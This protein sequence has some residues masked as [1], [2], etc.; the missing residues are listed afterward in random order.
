MALELNSIL[1]NRYQ[2][3]GLAAQGGMGSVYRAF[4]TNL[5]VP[6]A[7]KE[8]HFQTQEAR[9]QFQRE[10][11][12]LARLRHPG[13]PRVL[14]HFSH[15]DRQYLVMEF[16]EGPD[17]WE[18]VKQNGGPFP[19]RQ[20]LS[21][22]DQVCQAVSYLHSQV[23]P[24]IH[25]DIK[26]Q[27][28]KRMPND[29]VVLVDFGVAKEGETNV[30]TAAGAR[31]VTPGFSPPEQYSG[32]SGPA[33]DIYS[34]G[35]TL[36]AL[37]TGVKP[38]D[39]VS[40]AIG[41]VLY[42]PP[43]QFNRALST[44]ISQSISWAMQPR[45]TDRPAYVEAWRLRLLENLSTMPETKMADAVPP[46]LP[47]LDLS[48]STQP[49]C[50]KCGAITRPGIR[51]CEECGEDLKAKMPPPASVSAQRTKLCQSCGSINRPG[52]QFCEVCG[53]TLN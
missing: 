42:V 18:L 50:P 37:L 4:D 43:E 20:A 51:F 45:P 17:L 38:P 34:L 29:Q 30:Q 3:E 8:N 14:Q 36:Y 12:I 39:S 5:H 24:I 48:A 49:K 46:S 44:Y 25:R 23:P 27:N 32:S 2:I 13:L 35:A 19:E 9:E 6:V 28:I 22:L 7:I 31:G 10:A 1:E 33:S 11:L 41:Q 47:P 52:V 15:L 40:L 16:I 26:P 53:K 21:W